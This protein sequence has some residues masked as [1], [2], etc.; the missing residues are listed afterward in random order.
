VLF[1]L[2]VLT[3]GCSASSSS[4]D[5]GAASN[6]AAMPAK[7]M[8]AEFSS[9]EMALSDTAEAPAPAARESQKAAGGSGFGQTAPAMPAET[10]QPRRMLIYKAN[11]TMEVKSYADAYTEIQNL[12]HLSGGY[13]VQFTE[14]TTGSERSGTFTIKVPAGDF[15]GFLER[16]ED[17]PSVSLNR[18]MNA[19]DV[20]EEYVDLEARLKAKQ[21]VESRYMKYMEQAS[22]AEDLIRYTNELAAIQE[23][24]ERFKGRMRYLEQNVSFST[25]ELRVYERV[26][27]SI[28]NAGQNAGGLAERMGAA[29]QGSLHVLV[30]MAEGVMIVVAAA[31][32]VIVV[33]SL[34]G[35]P[36]YW[37]I[38]RR[39]AR[40]EKN[41]PLIP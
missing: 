3:A 16:I 27:A 7:E 11:L 31:I 4:M 38:R 41:R 37:W 10:D 36:I 24:I 20:S 6:K 14:Q 17:I 25:V 9:S 2:T 23:D 1:A 30:T 8:K 33:G 35:M 34:F 21:L 13:I 22:R 15:N 19:Q 12:I 39:K 5:T 18:S 40:N 29:L 28:L 32:P 26:E